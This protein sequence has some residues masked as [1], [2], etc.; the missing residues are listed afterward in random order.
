MLASV[1]WHLLVLFGGLFVVTGAIGATSLSAQAVSLLQAGGLSFEDPLLLASATT[2]ADPALWVVKDDDT[3]NY[4][5]GTIHVLK[6]GLSW[7]DEA[8]R[9][10]FDAS[11]ELVMGI[12]QTDSPASVQALILTKGMSTD[13]PT[14]P[15][16]PHIGRAH[17]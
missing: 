3:T 4:L 5:F 1:D 11:D 15:T 2:D 13:G 6:P 14:L 8:V 7:F 12:V 10:A 17:A 9:R 16:R